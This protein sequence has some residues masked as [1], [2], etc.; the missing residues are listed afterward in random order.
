MN[1]E[2]KV[3]N[4]LKVAID[5]SGLEKDH[6]GMGFFLREFLFHLSSYPQK[7][8]KFYLTTPTSETAENFGFEIK[9]WNEL[10]PSFLV[11]F[12]FNHPTFPFSGNYVT[13]IHD[14]AAFAFPEG[15]KK[16][17]EKIKIGAE[18]S[19]AIAADS[20]FTLS[21]I[22]K[23]LN[24]QESKISVIYP[25]FNPERKENSLNSLKFSS[26]YILTVGSAEYRKNF[27]T[28]IHAFKKLKE[29]GFAHKLV[30]IGDLPPWKKKIGPVVIEE[31]N[32][33]LK[34]VQRLNLGSEVF[35]K[36]YVPKK[37]LWEW[38]G[39]ASLFVFP[40]LY[41][42]FGFP[43]L[44]A[45]SCGI[46]TA[47]SQEASLPEVGGE[48]AFYFDPSSPDKMSEIMKEALTNK[49]EILR[50]KMLQKNSLDKFRFNFCIENY[51]NLFMNFKKQ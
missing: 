29:Q 36:G 44:E 17:Q 16:L 5:A 50:K 33:I 38:Y 41:E 35:L 2:N 9:K 28:L 14:L 3:E 4:L 10:D 48:G 46:S 40:S 22:K 11:W 7:S 18:H 39:N 8:F 47:L 34:L 27:Q 30:I 15:E 6:R 20:Q 32:P 45:Y 1:P 43:V 37:V 26:P 49:A 23:F 19:K 13:T 24:L 51:L 31:K 42:G 21:E 25:G 12:P